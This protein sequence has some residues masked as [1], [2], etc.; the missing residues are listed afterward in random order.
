MTT[1]TPWRVS[2]TISTFVYIIL[3]FIRKMKYPQVVRTILDFQL[4]NNM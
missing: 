3:G 4:H 1:F 2:G